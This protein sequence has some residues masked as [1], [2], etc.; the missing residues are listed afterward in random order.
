MPLQVKS[1]AE[2]ERDGTADMLSVIIPPTM[3]KVIS[4]ILSRALLRGYRSRT[5]ATRSWW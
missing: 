5:S 1:L 4:P 2:W 3:R